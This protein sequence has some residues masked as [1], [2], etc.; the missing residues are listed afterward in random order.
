[1]TSLARTSSRRHFARGVSFLPGT[2]YSTTS[3]VGCCD[4][5]LDE[6]YI[7]D[8]GAGGLAVAAV[9]WGVGQ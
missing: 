6:I 7:A 8:D 2:G 3:K 1:M 9:T 5:V 4:V